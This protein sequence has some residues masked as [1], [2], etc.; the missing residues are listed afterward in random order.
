MTIIHK[1]DFVQ[2]Q[3]RD[4]EDYY[5]CSSCGEQKVVWRG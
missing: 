1:H 4:Y 2:T 3:T 5:E